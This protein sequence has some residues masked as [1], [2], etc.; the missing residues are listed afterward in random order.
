M[1]C[2]AGMWHCGLSHVFQA[3]VAMDSDVL[4]QEPEVTELEVKLG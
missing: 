1:R 3:P 2:L 4:E